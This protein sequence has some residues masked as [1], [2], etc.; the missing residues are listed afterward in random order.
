[1]R[2]M[3]TY[4]RM[5]Q[6][7]L[8][9]EMNDE[10][11]RV[12]HQQMEY[13]SS[14]PNADTINRVKGEIAEV[15]LPHSCLCS[16]TSYIVPSFVSCRSSSSGLTSQI[17]ALRYNKHNSRPD[18]RMAKLRPLAGRKDVSYSVNSIA[19][20]CVWQVRAVM[21]ENIDKVLDR[22]DRIELLVDKTT[23]IQDNSFRFKKQSRRLRQSMWIKNAKLL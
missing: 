21:V 12:L 4:G 18:D 9:Y 5:A 16:D 8:A 23:T 3:K 20:I 11:S 15:D 13:F 14:N 19:E 7:A 2:F 17:R 22:G 1:M 6:T 10:F